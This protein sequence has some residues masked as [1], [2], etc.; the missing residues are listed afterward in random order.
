M[1]AVDEEEKRAGIIAEAM[2]LLETPPLCEMTPANI[3][4]CFRKKS[5]IYHPDKVAAEA[6]EADR[7]WS[8]ILWQRLVVAKDTLHDVLSNRNCWSDRCLRRVDEIYRSMNYSQLMSKINSLAG[9]G[10]FHVRSGGA[11]ALTHAHEYVM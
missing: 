8:K 1:Q 6:S 9:P 2:Q 11:M 5:L 3:D 4:S 10:H 7:E